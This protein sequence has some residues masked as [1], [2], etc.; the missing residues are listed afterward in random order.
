MKNRTVGELQALR[1]GSW[2]LMGLGAFAIV[3]SVWLLILSLSLTPEEKNSNVHQN[4]TRDGIIVI[5]L[6]VASVGAGWKL[7][8]YL[9]ACERQTGLSSRPFGRMP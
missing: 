9:K 2:F 3:I 1:A 8:S 6:A 5:V 7:R 4:D